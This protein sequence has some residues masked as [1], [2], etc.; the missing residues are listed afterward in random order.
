MRHT[1]KKAVRHALALATT[2]ADSRAVMK[3]AIL[4]A[5]YAG[6]SVES[7]SDRYGISGHAVEAIL[8]EFG[9]KGDDDAPAVARFNATTPPEFVG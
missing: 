3:A 1:T 8:R 5:F 4:F 2:D 6:E 9:A 7:L